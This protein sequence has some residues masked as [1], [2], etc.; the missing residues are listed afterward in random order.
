MKLE[1]LLKNERNHKADNNKLFI[2][3]SFTKKLRKVNS[4]HYIHLQV[5]HP[6]KTAVSSVA[7]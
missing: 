4:V 3:M 6:S 2:E 1:T 5:E 7:V